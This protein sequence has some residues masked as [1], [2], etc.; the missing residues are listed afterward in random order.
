MELVWDC[1]C[2]RQEVKAKNWGRGAGG[3]REIGWQVGGF[4]GWGGVV[5]TSLMKV[6]KT[7]R[8]THMQ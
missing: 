7:D 8:R 3:C 5:A 1:F 6:P 2:V 4:G